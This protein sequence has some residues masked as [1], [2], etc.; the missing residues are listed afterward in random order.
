MFFLVTLI[1]VGCAS[2]PSPQQTMVDDR[3]MVYKEMEKAYRAAEEDYLNL[4][5]NIERMP[6]EE[7][8]WI[9]KRD[10]MLELMQLKELMLNARAELDQAMQ[11]W[12]RHMIDLQ[13]EQK[14]AKVKQFSPNL[15]GK[16]AE[17]TS[18]GQLLP[19]DMKPKEKYGEL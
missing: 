17:R 13:A 19:S 14:K 3:Y 4:L 7:E 2:H 11:E 16:D 18:P 15:K 8:L 6:E 9:M 12:E 10:R 5:F 1:L